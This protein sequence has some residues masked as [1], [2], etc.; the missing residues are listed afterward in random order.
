MNKVIVISTIRVNGTRFDIT[1]FVDTLPSTTDKRK[2]KRIRRRIGKKLANVPSPQALSPSLLAGDSSVG[3]FDIGHLTWDGKTGE[4]PE[5][6]K[7]ARNRDNM[8]RD[9]L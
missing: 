6:L 5:W 3:V 2:A 1:P 4:E 8:E 7:K 9:Y